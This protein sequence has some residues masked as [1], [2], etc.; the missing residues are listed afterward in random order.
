MQRREE[1]FEIPDDEPE[2]L[3]SILSKLPKPLDLEGLIRRT[4]DLLKRLPP[5]SLS[6]WRRIS[7][8][9]VLKTSRRPLSPDTEHFSK[10]TSLDQAEILFNKQCRE[11]A[12]AQRRK[13]VYEGIAK[14][15]NKTIIVVS[16]LVGVS[17]IAYAIYGRGNGWNDIA[18]TGAFS[19]ISRLLVGTRA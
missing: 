6:T 7:H 12:W 17:S 10:T 2:M 5:E 1:L 14:H 8:I 18:A 13:R 15:K 19:Y 11:L 4:T 3:H 16:V 9:S